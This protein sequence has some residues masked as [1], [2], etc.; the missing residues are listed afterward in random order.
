MNAEIEVLVRVILYDAAEVEHIHHIH[1]IEIVKVRQSATKGD[2]TMATPVTN[3]AIQ[4]GDTAGPYQ[5]DG[6]AADGTDLGLDPD[7]PAATS[8]DTNVFTVNDLANG[9]FSL[10]G[11]GSISASAT[12]QVTDSQN[13]T[14]SVPVT[15]TAPP[16]PT[17]DH[18][19]VVSLGA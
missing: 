15:I 7:S 12:L 17:I 1:H 10:L 6:F 3:I 16:A 18:I 8:S 11:H 9:Q 14:V 19:G 4:Q 2:T 13:R 5:V